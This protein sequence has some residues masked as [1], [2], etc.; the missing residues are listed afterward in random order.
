[1]SHKSPKID[2]LLAGIEPVPGFDRHYVGFFRC[3]NSQ[4]YYEAHDVLEEVWLPI[5]GQPQAKFYQGLIQMAGG[6]VHLQKGRLDPAARLFALALKN[7][8]TYPSR[9]AGVDLEALRHLCQH[10]REEIIKSHATLNP[11]SREHPPKL[12]LPSAAMM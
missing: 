12:A 6:F 7:F 2:A 11:W 4:H 9:H 8:E 1:M 5:R 3:F 10:H